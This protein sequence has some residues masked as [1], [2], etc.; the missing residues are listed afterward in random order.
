MCLMEM[1]KNSITI[2][3]LMHKSC[4]GEKFC[5]YNESEKVFIYL[6]FNRREAILEWN[7]MVLTCVEKYLVN[8][9]F[10]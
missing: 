3:F 4:D 8:P 7:N 5:F 10:L 1:E 6:Y 9:R 2:M